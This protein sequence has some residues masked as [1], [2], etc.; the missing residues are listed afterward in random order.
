MCDAYSN[1]NPEAHGFPE[2]EPVD[3]W[4]LSDDELDRYLEVMKNELPEKH[5][6]LQAFE[7]CKDARLAAQVL[8]P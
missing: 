5:Q 7:K 1:G 3:P 8:V 2:A 4:H 6:Q